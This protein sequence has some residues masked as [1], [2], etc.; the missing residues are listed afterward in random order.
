[1]PLVQNA[2]LELPEKL[3]LQLYPYGFEM[4]TRDNYPLQFCQPLINKFIKKRLL[5]PQSS[6]NNT[7]KNF[8]F[9]RILYYLFIINPENFPWNKILKCLID[10]V[11]NSIRLL[12][13]ADSNSI[14]IIFIYSCVIIVIIIFIY[15]FQ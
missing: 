7:F 11:K 13:T 14:I 4:E 5:N 10:S 15:S 12:V 9:I 3:D 2:M 8:Q 6:R 1:M